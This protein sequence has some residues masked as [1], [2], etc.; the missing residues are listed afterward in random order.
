[1]IITDEKIVQDALDEITEKE[2]FI[3]I[4]KRDIQDLFGKDPQMR[5]IQVAANSFNELIPLVKRDFDSIGDLPD[6]ILVVY[7]C[8]D[9]TVSDLELLSNITRSASRS[10][11]AIILEKSSRGR[12]M[13]Y[14]F[15]K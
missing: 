5:M 1:M 13:V 10:R 15:F 7:V 8:L 6:K 12:F 9:L 11:R 3:H 14:Y 4:D 2:C